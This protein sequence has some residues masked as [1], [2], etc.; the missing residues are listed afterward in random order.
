MAFV[1]YSGDFSY[2][3]IGC[4]ASQSMVQ[5]GVVAFDA[6]GWIV[7]A[8][9]ASSVIYGVCMSATQTSS[10]TAGAT[11]VL[12][13][14]FTDNQI[15]KVDTTTD[16]AQTEIGLI[17]SLTDATTLDQDDAANTPLFMN[18]AIFGATT[19]RKMLVRPKMANMLTFGA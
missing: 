11:K 16:C 18:V 17:T 5:G 9:A 2:Q 1:P 19:D 7:P 13:V 15:W 3:E 8:T 4:A 12:V 10:A 6:S 14:P